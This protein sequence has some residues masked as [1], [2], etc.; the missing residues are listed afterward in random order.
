MLAVVDWSTVWA[1]VFFT[2][3]WATL[4]LAGAFTESSYKWGFFGFAVF[5]NVLI[6]W[7]LFGVGRRHVGR[8]EHLASKSFTMLAAWQVF[9]TY[10]S[11]NPLKFADPGLTVYRFMYAVAWAT[12]EGSNRI[13]VDSEMIFYAILDTLAFGV[14]ALLLVFKTRTL[15]L[16]YL[17]LTSHENGRLRDGQLIGNGDGTVPARSTKPEAT[18]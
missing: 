17:G 10:A 11:Y 7:L 2:W 14:F 5:T 6:A 16:D 18:V 12:A 13:H 3:I 1:T 4:Y 15:D 8:I 9:L